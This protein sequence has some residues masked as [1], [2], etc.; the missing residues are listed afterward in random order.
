LVFSK[1]PL[2]T[3]QRLIEANTL[4]ICDIGKE[5][6]YSCGERRPGIGFNDSEIFAV[7]SLIEN[8]DIS[9]FATNTLFAIYSIQ[10]SHTQSTSNNLYYTHYIVSQF[11]ELALRNLKEE[12]IQRPDFEEFFKKNVTEGVFVSSAL[13]YDY[14]HVLSPLTETETLALLLGLGNDFVHEEGCMFVTEDGTITVDLE[15][16][17]SPNVMR[18]Y[19]HF[20]WYFGGRSCSKSECGTLPECPEEIW[21]AADSFRD[22]GMSTQ[23]E[24]AEKAQEIW[25]HIKSNNKLNQWIDRMNE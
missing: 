10:S 4:D 25:N 14:I 6:I 17:V 23:Y 22:H 3:F 1:L 8:G 5:L 16:I 11:S 7:E 18:Y 12:L 15:G 19:P 21:A 20:N 2:D 9:F 13:I 24:G